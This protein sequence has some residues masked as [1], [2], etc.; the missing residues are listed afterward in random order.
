[1]P[2]DGFISAD[3]H[4]N[5]PP[6]AWERI[7]SDLRERGPHFVQDPPGKKGLYIC[8]EGHEPDPVGQ[9]FLAGTGR[10]PAIVKETIETFTWDKW[11]GPW[12]PKARLGDMDL[13]GVSIEV[14]YPSMARNFYSLQG[15]DTP[16]QLAGIRAYNDWIMEY[17]S[18]VPKRLFAVAILSILDIQWSVE[19][20]QR[21]AKLG[22]KGVMLPAGLPP[23]MSYADPEFEPIW[24]AAEDLALPVHF[25]INIRQSA[26]RK[27]LQRK[28]GDMLQVG[29]RVVKRAMYESAELMTDL[30]FGLVLENHPRLRVVFAEYELTWVLPFM[31]RMDGNARRFGQENPDKPHMTTTPSETIRRQVRFTFQN[32][33]AG[34]AGIAA[35]GMLDNC[36][37]ASDYPHGGATWPNSQEIV[38]AQLQGME[39]TA[40]E[41]LVWGNAARF[42]GIG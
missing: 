3:S 17:C 1:M 38:K 39:D 35:L 26:D 5:E 20:M 29:K 36:M 12:D 13:D 32:D 42:Y 14:L 30:L 27:V 34:I 33:P 10:E 22:H 11:P 25:H 37:W 41:N 40:V 7:P 16:L 28:E 15:A 31:T 4:V 8:F 21:C 23:G 9:T 24:T 18:A 2:L 19:E 6:E